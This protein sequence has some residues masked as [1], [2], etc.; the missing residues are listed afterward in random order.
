MSCFNLGNFSIS[1]DFDTVCY[2]ALTTSLYGNDL[3]AGTIIYSDSGCTSPYI[4][5]IFSD[6]FNIYST[7]GTG[8]LSDPTGCTCSQFYCIENTDTYDDEYVSSGFYNGYLYYTGQTNN[9]YIYFSITQDRWCLSSSLGGSCQ[10]FGSTPCI[11]T[12]P[13]LCDSLFSS[14]YCPTTT[15]TTSNFCD[16]D[17]IDLFTCNIPIS[18]TPTGTPTPTP[19]PT[20]TPTPTNPCGLI[21]FDLDVTSSTPTPTP[22]PTC[23]PTPSAQI[24]RPCNYV[25][26]VTFNTID[27]YLE[28]PVSK[29]FRDCF[30][31]ELYYTSNLTKLLNGS[32]PR[33]G[34]VYDG[35]INEKDVCVVFDGLRD[36]I[37]GIDN[38][39]IFT[40]LGLENEGA[41]LSCAP[42][43]VPTS[44]QIPTTTTTTT[45]CYECLE[46]L[47]LPQLGSSVQLNSVTANAIGSGAVDL[48]LSPAALNPCIFG[49]DPVI[50]SLRL[51][52]G[53]NLTNPY[54]YRLNFNVPVN[55]I[56]LR[57]IDYQYISQSLQEVLTFTVS[58]GDL[59]INSCVGC[60]AKIFNNTITAEPCFS[61]LRPGAG[62]FTF[63]STQPF[64]YLIIQGLGVSA[65][66]V[67]ICA[68]SIE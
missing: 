54:D 59:S 29:Q 51:G 61:D 43:P 11:T 5:S 60:C 46:T 62:I 3:L 37:S 63:T 28:C 42:T 12:C 45:V 2:S 68:D 6:G 1:S 9:Y 26:K 10:L 57:I 35:T 49:P 31:G 15:T 48:N 32:N 47:T 56:A 55:S 65:I 13:D 4:S 27:D 17:F 50:G 24:E 38:I 53:S 18:P 33:E 21:D 34:Y 25:G 20:Q 30:T 39:Q 16:I 66:T 40:E 36:N 67:D 7:N 58:D 22:T 52:Y 19:T 8:V 64:Q 41:C 23:T 14:G 44:T